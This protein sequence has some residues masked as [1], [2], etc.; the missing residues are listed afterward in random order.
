[1]D[2]MFIVIDTTF[3][4]IKWVL[5]NFYALELFGNKSCRLVGI[6]SVNCEIGGETYVFSVN[7][8]AQFKFYVSYS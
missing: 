2:G 5:L 8:N 1:M 7:I 6:I 3:Y 4:S